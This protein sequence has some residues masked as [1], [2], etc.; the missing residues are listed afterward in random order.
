M[1]AKTI[2]KSTFYFISQKWLQL[3]LLTFPISVLWYAAS[4]Y[5]GTLLAGNQAL[6]VHLLI[7]VVFG[8]LIEIIV[9]TYAHRLTVN[10]DIRPAGIYLTSL[11]YW[12]PVMQLSLLKLILIGIGLM[13]FILPGIFIAV[14]LA[15]AE[16]HLILR[17]AGVIESM[18]RSSALTA[19]NFLVVLIVLGNLFLL[20]L[21]FEYGSALLPDT[22]D[23]VLFP[24]GILIA[25]FSTIAAYRIYTLIQT[26]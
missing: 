6:F 15:L 17:G 25:S 5:A 1:H 19:P 2:L 21:L 7:G 13:M 9:I 14:R 4:H 23:I 3:L 26:S 22:L 20:H 12:L 24:L 8:S 11:T 16:Q 18:R 10:A